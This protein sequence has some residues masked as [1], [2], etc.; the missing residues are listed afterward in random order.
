ME[1][2]DC[3][4]CAG[5]GSSGVDWAS[6]APQDRPTQAIAQARQTLEA[7]S[8]T[9]AEQHA[10]LDDVCQALACSAYTSYMVLAATL[11]WHQSDQAG[12]LTF[13]QQCVAQGLLG[14][15]LAWAWAFSRED[16]ARLVAHV[17]ERDSALAEHVNAQAEWHE[18]VNHLPPESCGRL[19]LLRAPESHDAGMKKA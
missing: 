9:D 7:P 19:G 2:I 3:S 1:T 10:A 6:L 15:L 18:V 16:P 5:C 4:Q 14:P 12:F 8:A 11:A 17:R 13:A